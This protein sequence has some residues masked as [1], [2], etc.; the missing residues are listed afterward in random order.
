MIRRSLGLLLAAA[1]VL[2]ATYVS[3][4]RQ[5][6]PVIAKYPEF[7]EKRILEVTGLPVQL[8]SLQGG[9]VGFNPVIEINGLSLHVASATGESPDRVLLF[10]RGSVIVD[11]AR[12]IWQRRWVLHEF[13]VERLELELVQGSDGAWL[14]GDIAMQQGGSIDPDALYQAFL[15]ITQLNMREL[16][17]NVRTRSGEWLRFV[18]GTAKIHNHGRTHLLHVDIHPQGQERPIAL[19]F[20]VRGRNLAAIDGSL[21]VAM[22]NTN[23]AALLDGQQLAGLEVEELIGGGEFWLRFERGELR[24][25]VAVAEL[26]SAFVRRRDGGAAVAISELIGSVEASLEA[27]AIELAVA[28]LSFDHA[29]MHWQPSN[30]HLVHEPGKALALRADRLAVPIAD[31]LLRNLGLLPP[32][33]A[34]FLAQLAPGGMLQNIVLDAPLEEGSGEPIVFQANVD[35]GEIASVRSSPAITGLTG[36]LEATIDLDKRHASGMLEVDSPDFTINIPNLYSATWAYD[37][38][39]GRM[40]FELDYNGERRLRL[41]S[42]VL[43]GSAGATESRLQ[44]ASSLVQQPD[45]ER[46]N[47]LELAVSMFNLD[48]AQK[49]P[50]L[51]DGP[52]VNDG[53]RAGMEFLERAVV[54]G[55]L[56]NGS[57]IFRGATVKGARRATR[58]FQSVFQWLDG[59]LRFDPEWPALDTSRALVMTSNGDADIFVENGSSLGLE[60]AALRGAIREQAPGISLLSVSGRGTAS[61]A[62]ALAYLHAAPVAAGLREATA[63]WRITGAAA[64]GEFELEVPLGRTDAS[65]EMRLRLGLRDS[66]LWIA[67]HDLDLADI[68]GE[69]VFDTRTGIERGDFAASLFGGAAAMEISSRGARPVERIVVV[70]RGEADREALLQWPRQSEFVR[71][72]LRRT[73]GA[74]RYGAELH[75]DQASGASSLRIASDLAGL[76]IDLPEPFGKP[77]EQPV[78]FALQ[79][80]QDDG[81]QSMSGTVGGDLRFHVETD[82]SGLRSGRVRLGGGRGASAEEEGAGI[83][84]DGRLERLVLQQWTEL[85]GEMQA[86]LSPQSLGDLAVI[87]IGVGEADVYGQLLD[88]LHLRIDP[89]PAGW[90]ATMAGDSIEGV[91]ELPLDASDYLQVQLEHLRFR[92]EG[93]E[94]P[95]PARALGNSE[96]EAAE[97]PRI[98]RFVR[99]DPRSLPRMKFSAGEISVAG[100]PWGSWQFTLEPDA[101]GA[102]FNELAFDFRGLRMTG[103]G[104]ENADSTPAPGLRWQ[105]DGERHATALTGLIVADDLAEVLRDNGFAASLASESARFAVALDWPGSPASFRAAE[106]DGS[107]DLRVENGRFLETGADSGAL[108]LIS[109][110]NFDAIMRR[111]RLSDDLFR[112]GLAFDEISGRLD[113][114]GGLVRLDEPLVISGPSSLY[115]IIGTIDLGKELISGEMYVTLP[116]SDNI[117]WIGL[118]T[119]NFP[120]AIGAFLIDQIFGQQVDSLTSAVYA[121]E[122]PWEGLEP[123]FKQAFGTPPGKN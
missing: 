64:E 31:S 63:D 120:L 113:L 37:R 111:L 85:Q 116:L 104:A 8:E 38:V 93:E 33:A 123:Q 41:A 77:A 88:E 68:D 7:V 121:L 62:D 11:M 9:F 69:L 115:Q 61:P 53:L 25:V 100:T 91:I 96:E 46:S 2:V 20:E 76:A 23:A 59:S 10:D 24:H 122:G 81:A 79:I 110:L 105:Y 65:S 118:M 94:Q 108:K 103:D 3:V 35:G 80:D 28:G 60:A 26:E 17:V 106:L 44:L 32:A 75:L 54:D 102:S 87:D 83:V 15:G 50:F 21:H 74:L 95:P 6:M 92:G 86:M 90:L 57:A 4:G 40:G 22:P 109:I 119:S 71:G 18:N 13:V 67:Q 58:T 97:S 66:D 98:D 117:P 14:L 30:L 39:N 51:P 48:A 89:G 43:A 70:S 78:R 82:V 114:Q 55:R 45:G 12:S 5:F 99:V 42:S 19:S 52:R 112:R 72:L 107:L 29:G 56:A 84:I 34:D 49:N 73:R 16:A 1:V 101:A 27:A 47:E 36:Y